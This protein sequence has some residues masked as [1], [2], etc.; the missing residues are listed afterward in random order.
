MMEHW[1]HK[2]MYYE[3]NVGGQKKSLGAPRPVL[4]ALHWISSF[5]RKFWLF[6]TLYSEHFWDQAEPGKS[7]S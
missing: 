7:L 4:G 3:R 1:L 6:Q 5:I 2:F